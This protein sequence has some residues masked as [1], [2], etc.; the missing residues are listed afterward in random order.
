MLYKENVMVENVNVNS[1][2]EELSLEDVELITSVGPFTIS[3]SELPQTTVIG[4][5]EVNITTELNADIALSISTDITD[6]T[7]SLI[8]EEQ[9]L[10]EQS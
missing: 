5:S 9:F 8:T 3:L 6:V 2:Q 7:Y 4:A 1:I 10:A